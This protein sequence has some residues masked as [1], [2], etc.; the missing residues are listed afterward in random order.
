MRIQIDLSGHAAMVKVLLHR[1][2]S[3]LHFQHVDHE[4]GTPENHHH[5]PSIA[6]R[7]Q[8]VKLLVLHELVVLHFE[9]GLGQR[10]GGGGNSLELGHCVGASAHFVRV[11]LEGE[12]AVL[13]AN[14]SFA[15]SVFKLEGTVMIDLDPVGTVCYKGKDMDETLGDAAQDVTYLK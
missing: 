2:S 12:T 3:S 8:H 1:L 6:T 10:L 4:L 13:R 15:C 7:Q 9:L 11:V 5:H 14:C